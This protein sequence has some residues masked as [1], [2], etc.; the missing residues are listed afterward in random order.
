MRATSELVE[1]GPIREWLLGISDAAV[2]KETLRLEFI[3]RKGP[4]DPAASRCIVRGPGGLVAYLFASNPAM[5]LQVKRQP[6]SAA[7]CLYIRVPMGRSLD[8][9]VRRIADTIAKLCFSYE[10]PSAVVT[11]GKNKYRR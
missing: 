3:V 2:K 4:V 8:R 11:G 9:E 5:P 10:P 1:T 6:E 7:A